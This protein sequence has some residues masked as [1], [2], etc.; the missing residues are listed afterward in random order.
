M[1]YLDGLTAEGRA[2]YEEIKKSG[3]AP[4]YQFEVGNIIVPDADFKSATLQKKVFDF[5]REHPDWVF[6]FERYGDDPG[7][8]YLN[9]IND[10]F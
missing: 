4:Y 10:L 9:N 6:G 7:V 8:Y 5:L 2:R 3:L 1:A